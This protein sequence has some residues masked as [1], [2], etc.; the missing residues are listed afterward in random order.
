[1]AN[2]GLGTVLQRL[3]TLLGPEADVGETDR[4]LLRRFVAGRDQAAF[5]E[6]VRRHGPMVYGVCRRLS[7]DA[8]A[9]E[10]AFQATFLVLARRA[11]AV[12]WRAALGGWLHGVAR[13]VALKARARAARRPDAGRLPA[14]SPADPA[15]EAAARE[16]RRVLDQ[17]LAGL[18]DKYRA[19]LVLCD[20]EGRTHEEAARE[21]GWPKGSMAKRLSGARERLRVRLLRRGVAPAA[22]AAALLGARELTA[23]VP[24]ELA[25]AAA[26][27]AGGA[28]A[29]AAAA[30][31]K[32]V[33][34]TMWLTRITTTTA[35]LA[36]ALAGVGVGAGLW[37]WRAPAALT[38]APAPKDDPPAAEKEATLKIDDAVIH[39]ESDKLPVGAAVDPVTTLDRDRTRGAAYVEALDHAAKGRLALPPGPLVL[40][41]AGPVLNSPDEAAVVKLTRRGGRLDLEIV[42][43]NALA[44]GEVLK[45]NI[46][47]RPLA[48]VPAELP[49]G[50]Y[51]LTVTWR[52]VE[53][54]PDGKPHD[55]KPIVSTVAFTVLEG[56]KESKELVIHSVVFRAYVQGQ[57][58]APAAAGDSCPID[59]GLHI[60]NATGRLLTFKLMDTVWPVLKTADGKELKMDGGRDVTRPYPP[61]TLDAGKSADVSRAGR[62]EWPKDGTGLRL[63]GT[64]PSGFVWYFDGLKPGKYALSFRYENSDEKSPEW[65]GQAT[66]E[67]VVFEILPAEGDKTALPTDKAV[68]FHISPAEDAPAFKS[69]NEARAAVTAERPKDLAG[70]VEAFN[71]ALAE[72]KKQRPVVPVGPGLTALAA[73]PLLDLPDQATVASLTRRG[74]N[75]EM[76]FAYTSAVAEGKQLLRNVPWRPLARVPLDLPPGDYQLTVTW[77]ARATLPAGKPHDVKP[78]VSTAAFTVREGC[79][80]SKPVRV[81]RLEFTALAPA[82]VPAPAF[83][84]TR[85]VDLG[86]RIT[87]VSDKPLS[88]NVNDVVTPRLVAPDGKELKPSLGRDG[89]PRP[90]SPATLAPGESWE[91]RPDAKLGVTADRA[92]LH[93]YGP[94]GHGAPGF[95]E[96]ATLHPGKYTLVVDYINE[97]A[98]QD[99]VAL[100]VGKATTKGVD[101]EIVAPEAP[102]VELARQEVEKALQED[103]ERLR[104]KFAD[105]G[106]TLPEH[107]GVWIPPEP[108][109][110]HMREVAEQPDVVHIKWWTAMEGGFGYV[111]EA[112]VDKKTLKVRIVKALISYADS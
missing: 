15:A 109:A 76:E 75:L 12:P 8:H 29:P 58:Q 101:F 67:E 6:L 80:G 99:D 26:R 92:T 102:P 88:L 20:L 31:A 51:E 78:T 77:R 111:A 84:Q 70:A 24:A 69:L 66:T 112:E 65:V 90:K 47:W 83:G 19:P 18:P 93:L 50:R 89:S 104:K 100:W 86:L 110:Y 64:D 10:D 82:R 33:V 52:A 108:A 103:Y 107:K 34:Q 43:T 57:C 45:R 42:Y 106:K 85:D 35:V 9:A 25:E 54:L 28:A 32:G 30:L 37:A 91:W 87:N 11:A 13:R 21:L 72:G 48:E 3:R 97:A 81:E 53:K 36:V 39:H 38:A 17:E 74:D 63:G 4:R 60:T 95:W 96:F 2:S 71:V 49:P 61:I 56:R 5:A 105:R 1:M 27:A 68:I 55:I 98:Q 16:L 41:A 62:L 44:R 23:A 22:G 79:Q 14:P 7:A 40:F 94:D 59:L 73:G 46:P